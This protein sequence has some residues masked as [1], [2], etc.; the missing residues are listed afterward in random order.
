MVSQLFSESQPRTWTPPPAIILASVLPITPSC[1]LLSDL[2]NS[3]ENVSHFYCTGICVSLVSRERASRPAF[4]LWY[5]VFIIADQGLEPWLS[6]AYDVLPITLICKPFHIQPESLLL[7]RSPMNCLRF[8]SHK[9]I[10]NNRHHG[11]LSRLLNLYSTFFL[12]S[13]QW[14]DHSPFFHPSQ[15]WVND[16]SQLIVLPMCAPSESLRFSEL[17]S[18]GRHPIKIRPADNTPQIQFRSE[19]GVMNSHQKPQHFLGYWL[20]L[21]PSG[22]LA[23]LIIH[24]LPALRWTHGQVQ[25]SQSVSQGFGK[26]LLFNHYSLTF[27]LI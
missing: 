5:F 12:F 14:L 18:P 1:I 25:S 10:P 17:A 9:I 20:F 24:H 23:F 7:A 2:L 13:G 6:H 4:I 22:L 16:L 11:S 26:P 27:D 19:P 8:I 21:P 15:V 3:S